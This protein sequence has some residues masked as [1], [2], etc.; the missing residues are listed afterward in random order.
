MAFVHTESHDNTAGSGVKNG[1]FTRVYTDRAG[2]KLRTV[3]EA[4]DGPSQ[5]G[6]LNRLVVQD[7]DYSPAGTPVIA[8][9]PYFLDSGSSTSGEADTE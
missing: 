5:P 3:T 6:G 9:Q 2:R 1:P 7:T 4:Y 8:T